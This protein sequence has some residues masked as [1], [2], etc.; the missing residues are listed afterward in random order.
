MESVSLSQ[1][2]EAFNSIMSLVFV[3]PVQV[4]SVGR[5]NC[6]VVC[7]AGPSVS[8]TVTHCEPLLLIA[9]PPFE[10]CDVFLLIAICMEL[11]LCWVDVEDLLVS[12]AGGP[13]RPSHSKSIPS[14]PVS[15]MHRKPFKNL[16]NVSQQLRSRFVRG[17]GWRKE[18]GNCVIWSRSPCKKATGTLEGNRLAS[19]GGLFKRKSSPS[20]WSDTC[21][22]SIK[23][24]DPLGQLNLYKRTQV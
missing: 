3:L 20:Q 19:F 15:R 10:S 24:I 5:E 17:V 16:V 13:G 8:V 4:F 21:T 14:W 18:D 1:F 7:C 9:S 2:V 22:N 12:T 23:T 6:V 11:L